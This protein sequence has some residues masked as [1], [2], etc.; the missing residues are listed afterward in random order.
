MKVVKLN[1]LQENMLFSDNLIAI[2]HQRITRDMSEIKVTI[3]GLANCMQ[4]VNVNVSMKGFLA[5]NVNWVSVLQ[6]DTFKVAL[7]I[8]LNI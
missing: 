6:N 8:I 2:S 5:I 3:D 4:F 1:R 7:V